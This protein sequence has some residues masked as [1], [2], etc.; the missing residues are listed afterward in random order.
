[1]YFLFG[2]TYSI[3]NKGLNV[4][5]VKSC[6]LTEALICGVLVILLLLTE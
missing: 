1:M 6:S 5:S 2:V 4:A 3:N